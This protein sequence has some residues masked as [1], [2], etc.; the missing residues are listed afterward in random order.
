MRRKTEK[1]QGIKMTHKKNVHEK[2]IC[3]LSVGLNSPPH[4]MGILNLSPESFY[5]KS[6]TDENTI[7]NAAQKM[8]QEGATIVDVGARSTS[9][10]APD[11]PAD[12]EKERLFRAL[13]IL[14]GNIDAVISV[15][16]MYSDIA[17]GALNRGAHIINDESG[18]TKDP[19]M[20]RIISDYDA[21]AVLMATEKIRGDPLGMDS[22]LKSLEKIIENAECGGIDRNKIILDPAIGRWIPEKDAAYDYEVLDRFEELNVFNMPIMIALSR[23]SFM[24]DVLKKPAEG[25]LSGTLAAT[26]IA[27]YKGGRIIRAH[28]VSETVDAANIAYAV[29]MKGNI[30]I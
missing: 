16:T 5:K 24:Q 15:D 9:P 25:R 2:T 26:A 17:E 20:A 21:A 23:K 3:G 8:V 28:D 30:N 18:L 27:V 14:E 29:W 4:V 7:L 13:D 19:N 22:V 10:W 11:I 6:V 1:I 12:L